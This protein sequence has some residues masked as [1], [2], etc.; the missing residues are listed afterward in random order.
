MHTAGMISPRVSLSAP[1]LLLIRF[2]FR[3]PASSISSPIFY[4]SLKMKCLLVSES[5]KELL[6]KMAKSLASGILSFTL[7]SFVILIFFFF[8]VWI[9]KKIILIGR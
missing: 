2:R 3:S 8:G 7:V 4:Y 6:V 5:G 9:L 1:P